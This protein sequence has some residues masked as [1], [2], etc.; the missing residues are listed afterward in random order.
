LDLQDEAVMLYVGRI[1]PLK[2]LELGIRAVEELVRVRDGRLVFLCVGGASGGSGE[3]ELTRLRAL[4][5]SLGVSSDVRFVGATSHTRV[6]VFYRAADVA[7]VTSYSESFGLAAL[8]AHACGTPVVGTAVGGLSHIVRN[9]ESGWLVP[10]RDPRVFA[11]RVASVLDSMELRDSFSAAALR[12]AGYFS[13]EATADGLMELYDCLI[14]E[15]SPELCT[16]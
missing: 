10:S 3:R 15:R 14:H 6:P 4:A 11:D 9:G 1:Q 2:G 16:C 8:E 7:V 5:D 12:S 13:W